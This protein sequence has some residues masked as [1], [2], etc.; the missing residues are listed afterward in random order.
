MDSQ[1][2]SRRT[3]V[4]RGIYLQDN[5]KY[6][7]CCRHAGRLRFR[8]VEGDLAAAR[9]ARA[10]LVA[11]ARAGVE[12]VSPHL[13]FDTVARWWLERFEAKVAADERH[14]RTLEAHRYQLEQCLLP[15]LAAR[16]I[17][18]ITVDDVAEML[19]QLQHK[20]RSAKTSASA[21][22]TLH[23]V[24][25]FARRHGW[26]TIDPVAELE[27]DERP[28]LV[29]RR[30]RVLGRDE[31]ERLL[32]ACTAQ[33]RLIVATALF[34]GL[35]ISELLG[36]T[37]SDVDFAAGVLRVRAQLSR[38]HRGAPAVRVPPKTA[39]SHRDVPL[40]AQLAGLL[41]A[42]HRATRFAADTD[43][44]FTTSRGTP[45]SQRNINRHGLQRAAEIAGLGR[46]GWP[47]LRFHDLRHT[48]ASHLILDL[49]VDVAQVSHILGHA[50]YH[51]HARRL[52]APLRRGTPHPRN[53]HAHGF[54]RVRR[55]L[56]RRAAVSI[57]AGV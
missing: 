28:C 50:S 31:I 3:R 1:S 56:D 38:A 18:M 25:R 32:D 7:V 54:K 14:P 5:G 30:Q 42:H 41:I 4:E 51:R 37:W 53:T 15:A 12:P 26:V 10:A 16:R 23:S 21:L 52:H 55:V 36:L 45:H 24:L 33:Y 22:A 20:R 44:V 46:D 2:S 9:R 48:F 34:T 40:V 6:A 57:R 39:A 13:R 29:R 27:R 47:P 8:T 19:L 43:W 49:G 35:R 17:N 11:A